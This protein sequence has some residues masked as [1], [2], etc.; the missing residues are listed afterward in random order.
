LENII[1]TPKSWDEIWLSIVQIIAQ[2]SKDPQTKIG[3]VIVSPDNTRCTLG[4]NGF[5]VGIKDFEK[6]W[7]RPEKYSRVVHAEMNAI[8]NAKTD[9]NGWTLYV[10]MPPCD[11]CACHIIQAKISRIIWLN[12]PS[13]N[14]FNYDLSYQLLSE[15]GIK[16]GKYRE[17]NNA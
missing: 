7:E 11:R 14:A 1:N 3:T 15:A 4:F 2:K 8:L 13:S 12:D 9:L 5:P 6:R 17:N 10:S 16:F